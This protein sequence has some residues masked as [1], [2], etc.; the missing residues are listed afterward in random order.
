MGGMAGGGDVQRAREPRP[1]ENQDGAMG[2]L[3]W[4]D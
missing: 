4:Q 3:D 1:Y 2:L